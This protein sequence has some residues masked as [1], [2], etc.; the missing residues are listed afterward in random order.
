VPHGHWKTLTFIAALRCDRVIDGPTNGELFTLYVEKVLGPTRAVS[1]LGEGPDP[2]LYKSLQA[3]HVF[4]A[5]H[6]V[7]TASPC[8]ALQASASGV[9]GLGLPE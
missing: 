8:L 4:V 6:S 5:A 2:T 1:N 7:P 9:P 3:R